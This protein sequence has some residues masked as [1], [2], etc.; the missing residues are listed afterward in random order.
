MSSGRIVKALS[1]FYYVWTD[2]A[3][4]RLITCRARGIFKHKRNVITPLVG[5]Q[6]E[7]AIR[8]D[9]QE[10]TVTAVL[11]RQSELIRPPIANVTQVLV[12]FSAAEP[13]FQPELLDKFLLFI[14]HEG[15]SPLIIISKCDLL[16]SDEAANQKVK[17]AINSYR[18]IGYHVLELS[19]DHE[20]GLEPLREL[21]QGKVSVLAGQSGVGKSTLLNRLMPQR[22]AVE[23]G[24]VSNRLGRGRHTTRHVELIAYDQNG[25]LA[26]TPGFSQL[27]LSLL[28]VEALTNGYI[29]FRELAESCKFRGC[30]H[31]H[32]P[33][34][35][36][37]EAVEQGRIAAFRYASYSQWMNEWNEHK[38]RGSR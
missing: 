18:A 33:S 5:D 31:I 17:E 37:R 32:E 24:S 26:D 3:Q 6:V 11:P 28:P 29:E 36:V 16:E 25:W 20:Q 30:S 21:L 13:E 12:V 23:T 19:T 9:E 15:L 27:D 34:C 7:L 14:E 22:D 1:G 2:E 35:Q 8:A 4:P 10:G 38:R